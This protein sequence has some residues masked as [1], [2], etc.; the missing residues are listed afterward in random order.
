VKPEH[1]VLTAGATDAIENVI[2]AVCDDGDSVLMPGPHWPGFEIVLKRK[3]NVDLIAARPPTYSHWDNYLLPSLQAAYDFSDKKSRIRAVLLC[4][5]NNPL[6]RCYPRETLLELIEFCQERGLHLIC[7]EVSALI[8]LN[9]GDKKAPSFVSALSLTEPFVPEG[10]VKVDP[11]RV[12]VVW[13]ASKLFGMSGFKV[14]CIISQQNPSLLKAMALTSTHPSSIS[15]LYL[16]SLLTWSQLPTLLALN[17]ERLTLS[18]NIL[19]SFLRRH[20]IDFVT[21]THGLFLFA[22][23]A[24]KA[25]TVGDE[26]SFYQELE[27]RSGVKIA[28]GGV[29]NGVEKDAGWARMRFSI[30]VEDMGKAVGK[31]EAFFEKS[32]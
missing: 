3:A 2:Q 19:A 8:S 17:S 22:R 25:V 10:A 4:N 6:S 7:D 1:I 21:P 5:P 29:F 20:N 18:Y 24:K 31:L 9:G 12:H 11:S 15:T 16:N 23:L 14:G 32:G 27:L 30:S 13:S 28:S 26:N